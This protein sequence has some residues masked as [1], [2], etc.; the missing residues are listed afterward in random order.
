MRQKFEWQ[1]D[2]VKTTFGYV[3]VREVLDKPLYWFNYEV[4]NKMET[5][6]HCSV[7]GKAYI[8]AIEVS[9]STGYKF[10]IANHFGI[11]VNKLSK[12]GWPNSAHFSFDTGLIKFLPDDKVQRGLNGQFDEEGYAN[13]ESKRRIWQ[14]E[15]YPFEFEQMESLRRGFEKKCKP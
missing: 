7:G 12:G 9:T 4:L 14:K 13:R 11:G 5:G 2:P 8:A 3:A 6:D 10:Y 1:G 15:T